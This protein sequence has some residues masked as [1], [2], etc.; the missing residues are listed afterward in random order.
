MIAQ[1]EIIRSFCGFVAH[2]NIYAKNSTEKGGVRNGATRVQSFLFLFTKDY[3]N[4]KQIT[5]SWRGI[6]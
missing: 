3:T 5:V 4:L 6:L 2:I 1:A